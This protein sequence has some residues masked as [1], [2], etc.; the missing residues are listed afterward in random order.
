MCIDKI[1][2]DTKTKVS[3]P[4]RY[5]LSKLRL[6]H[7]PLKRL[8]QTHPTC[9]HHGVGRYA[10]HHP[11]VHAKKEAGTI[12]LAEVLLLPPAPCSGD[13]VFRCESTLFGIQKRTQLEI[14]G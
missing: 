14:R 1:P 3:K 11:N 5:S 13:A 9:L 8:I 6:V 10:K 4:K 12:T 2:E 7:A